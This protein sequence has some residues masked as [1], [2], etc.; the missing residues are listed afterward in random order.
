ML[1]ST[2]PADLTVTFFRK[3]PGHLLYPGRALCGELV[4]RDIGIATEVLGTIRPRC[5]ENAPDLWQALLPRPGVETHK[6]ERGHAAVFSGG[7]STTGA[8]RL[9]ARGAAR[10]GAGAVTVLSP[11]GALA[12]NAMHLTSIMLRRVEAVDELALFRRERRASAYVLGPGFGVGERARS[13]AAAVLRS[14][15]DVAT[16]HLVLDADG[17][18]AFAHEPELLFAAAAGSQGRLVLTPHPGEFARLFP[19]LAADEQLSKLGKARAAAAR[20]GAVV[21]FKGPDTVIAAPD[22][23]AVINTNGTAYL[24]TAGSGDVL[25]GM[26]CGLLAQQMPAFEAAAAAAYLHAEAGRAFGPGLIAEDLPEALPGVLDYLI[27][28]SPR[29]TADPEPDARSDPARLNRP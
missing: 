5:R 2:A 16:A 29:R 20:S 4:V 1:G 22:G 11:A 23:Q 7:P 19:D 27:R 25:A 8:A 12:V 3:K 6:Y 13:F 18:T 21:L 10:I 9:A 24:A 26:I 15:E 17:I 28:P 14:G